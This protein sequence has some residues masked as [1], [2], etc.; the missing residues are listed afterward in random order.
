MMEMV[1]HTEIPWFTPF[2]WSHYKQF[3]LCNTWFMWCFTDICGSLR[4]MMTG[5]H[6]LIESYRLMDNEKEF[7]IVSNESCGVY[8]GFLVWETHFH[9][10]FIDST[11][12]CDPNPSIMGLRQPQTSLKYHTRYY[13]ADGKLI[14]I[15]H[16]VIHLVYVTMISDLQRS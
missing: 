10:P 14:F 11:N 1:F 16:S 6:R 4:H 13:T 5:L 12:I 9:R 8:H 15:I 3:M 2:F 7:L